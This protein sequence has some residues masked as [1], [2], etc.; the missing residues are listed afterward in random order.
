MSWSALLLAAAAGAALIALALRLRGG[1]RGDLTGPPRRKPRRL[2]RQELDELT[3]LVGRGGE[4]E[5]VRRLKSAGYD[6]AATRR[7]VRLMGKVA[8]AD[9]E[10]PAGR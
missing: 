5:A 8:A 10:A 4:E 9:G 3:A 6:E 1:G 2:S 7:L